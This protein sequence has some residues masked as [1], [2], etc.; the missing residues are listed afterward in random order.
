VSVTVLRR[1]ESRK[2]PVVPEKRNSKIGW[3]SL[4]LKA[5]GVVRWTSSKTR[6]G[7]SRKV[8]GEEEEKFLRNLLVIEIY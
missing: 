2:P 1:E 4:L 8:R 3:T 5:Q 7:N 6:G